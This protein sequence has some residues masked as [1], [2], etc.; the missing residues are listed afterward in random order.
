[1]RRF[2]A[3]FMFLFLA[4]AGT[5]Y[6]APGLPYYL[7]LGDSLSQGVQPLPNGTLVNTNQG[8]V[9]GVYAYYK[10]RH[11]LLQLAKL[12]CSGDSTTIM[13][14]GGSH[15]KYPQGSQLKQ[16]VEFISKH[17]VVLVTLTV[18][19]DD[20]LGCIDKTAQ[21]S[22]TCVQAGSLALGMNL[23]QILIELRAALGPNVPIVASNYYDPFLA[24]WVL[25]PGGQQLATETWQLALE[26]NWAL[27]GL[28]GNAGVPVADVA[29]A[30]HMSD[31]TNVPGFNI[32]RNVFVALT[33]TWIASPPPR[34]PDVHPNVFGYSAM[35]TAFIK[36]IGP[37]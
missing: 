2:A 16:A 4:L 28:Y 17:N 15:C 33:W 13:R 5:A 8:Y 9:D 37:L 21:I 27:Q 22:L 24:A 35:A 10:L 18:G 14:F 6:G 26:L 12:G 29:G 19:G 1:M 30:F 36:T 25:L 34:G 32:P 11:P 7:A 23:P 31:F 3:V 20:V